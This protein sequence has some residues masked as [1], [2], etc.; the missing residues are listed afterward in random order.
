MTLSLDNYTIF[1]RQ[2]KGRGIV[3]DI[4]LFLWYK[5]IVLINKIKKGWVK[6]E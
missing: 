6:Q 2:L 1:K 5:K 4:T 3:I